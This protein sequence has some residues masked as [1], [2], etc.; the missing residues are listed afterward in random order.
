MIIFETRLREIINLLPTLSDG[1]K[2]RHGNGTIDELNKF[3][4]IPESIAKYPLIWLVTGKTNGN[5][6]EIS[7]VT[8]KTTLIIATKS[9][10]QN[11]LNN[12][13]L[14]KVLQENLSLIFDWLMIALSESGISH[15]IGNKFDYEFVPNYS[16]NNNNNGI[17]DIWDAIELDLELSINDKKCINKINF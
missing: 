3:L 2:V 7:K 15:I 12:V 13:I 17:I 16:I 14:E 9:I 6:N 4:T 5:L 1:S 8:R 11:E 10:M